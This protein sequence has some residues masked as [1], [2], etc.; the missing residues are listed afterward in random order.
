[1][2]T[3]VGGFFTIL[4]F[5]IA[6]YTHQWVRRLDLRISKSEY[7]HAD[8]DQRRANARFTWALLALASALLLKDMLVLLVTVLRSP[9]TEH[10]P[11]VALYIV[12]MTALV[13]KQ[14][15]FQL[16]FV[17]YSHNIALHFLFNT[18]FITSMTILL[19]TLGFE[20]NPQVH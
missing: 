1:M 9:H 4:L 13:V 20:R 8:E 10:W 6:E 18:V 2:V 19:L 12:L 15:M 11:P 5:A 7:A 16:R 14:V 17:Q 3:A